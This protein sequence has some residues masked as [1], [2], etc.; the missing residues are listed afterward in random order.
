MTR[1]V[2]PEA[3]RER[4]VEVTEVIVPVAKTKLLA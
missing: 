3:V 4:L 1:A 2:V